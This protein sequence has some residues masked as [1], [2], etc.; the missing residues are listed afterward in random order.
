MTLGH[1]I[2]SDKVDFCGILGYHEGTDLVDFVRI[3]VAPWSF[4]LDGFCA[5]YQGTM[6]VQIRW[7]LCGT[8]G[9]PWMLR[10]DGI[11]KGQ[12]GHHRG[13]A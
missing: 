11:C 3:I 8:S 10:F 1:Q 6:G 4:T 13:S 7:T 9:A 5:G 2:V 12:L